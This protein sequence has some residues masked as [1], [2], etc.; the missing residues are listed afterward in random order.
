MTQQTSPEEVARIFDAEVR[1]PGDDPFA[2]SW[3]VAPTDPVTVVLQRDDGRSVERHRWG[4]VPSWAKTVK[5]G[6]RHINAR[7]ETVAESASFRTSFRK[8][9]CIIPA[10]GFYEWRRIG[11][12]RKQPWFLGP[13]ADDAV[14]AM[15]GLWSVWKDPAT[16]LWVPSATVITTDANE[17][18][19][20]LHDR[21]PVLLPREAWQAW[22]DP[23]QQDQE[24][25]RSLL[26]PAPDGVLEMHPVS[27]RVNDV[28]EDGPDLMAAVPEEPADEPAPQGNV[29]T[30][31]AA[32]RR[33]APTG[34]GTLFD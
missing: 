2:P 5:E 12:K 1:D 32:R 28:R 6:A 31:S 18:V 16:G 25:L 4:L 9:R 11:E 19:G 34:Q 3:N 17:D 14:L 22:L 7:A 10:D 24:L 15:A 30:A 13:H 33:P 29:R 8:R 20:Q 23:E 21:M 26:G 27:R